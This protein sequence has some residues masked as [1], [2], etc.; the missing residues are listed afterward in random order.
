MTLEVEFTGFERA[1]K[2]LDK[3]SLEKMAGEVLKALAEEIK[4]LAI[5][6]PV[7]GPWNTPGPYPAKW[8]Q[9]QFGP[10]WALKYSDI[11]GGS[12]TSEQMQKQWVVE[13][14]GKAWV[15]A[16]RA[17]YAAYVMGEEQRSFHADHGWL[18]LEKIGK[19]VIAAKLN[20]LVSDALDRM[21][22]G[23]TNAGKP[24]ASK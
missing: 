11:P 24:D 6:Y 5:P 7:E 3:A 13:P 14:R 12:N 8:Y 10:R 2:L 20:K 18:K 21:I 4:V 16:N 17:S 1:M 23:G 15:V 9:R 19:D 22:A